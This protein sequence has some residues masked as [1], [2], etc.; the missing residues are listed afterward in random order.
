MSLSML[1]RSTSRRESGRANDRLEALEPRLGLAQPR[2]RRSEGRLGTS[3][4]R[5]QHS[6]NFF[7]NL[8]WARSVAKVTIS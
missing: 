4:R 6:V 1:R 3:P 7:A 5:V 8:I 2:P